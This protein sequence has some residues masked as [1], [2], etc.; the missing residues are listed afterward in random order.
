MGRG[1][2]GGP[3]KTGPRRSSLE[4]LASEIRD[5][6]VL[7]GWTTFPTTEQLRA[8]RRSGLIRRINQAGGVKAVAE[9]TGLALTTPQVQSAIGERRKYSDRE[10]VADA[11]AVIAEEGFLF[12]ANK[13]RQLG[14]P[15]LAYRV[16]QA[17]GATAF[18]RKH[19]LA[20]PPKRGSARRRI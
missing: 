3:E 1:Q 12:G 11:R 7:H 16:L 10:A 18:C 9:M 14:Y 15:Q 20:T 13:L 4:A 8:V 5:L 6:A 2:A 19:G 17:G